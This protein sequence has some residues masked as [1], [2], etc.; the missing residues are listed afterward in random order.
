MFHFCF[1]SLFNFYFVFIL[2]YLPQED[3]KLATVRPGEGRQALVEV[4]GL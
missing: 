2:F 1:G 3:S 4:H